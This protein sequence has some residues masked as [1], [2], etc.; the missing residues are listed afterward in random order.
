MEEKITA[1]LELD[2]STIENNINA[3]TQEKSK[4]RKFKVPYAK[5]EK[6]DYSDHIPHRSEFLSKTEMVDTTG[7]KNTMIDS[8]VLTC[9]EQKSIIEVIHGGQEDYLEIKSEIYKEYICLYTPA[10]IF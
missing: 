5:K 9:D 4:K 1:T 3:T 10:L 7:Q 8:S 6:Q 2:K